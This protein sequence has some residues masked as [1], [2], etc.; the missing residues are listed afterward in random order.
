MAHTYS[1]I[2]A[3][4]IFS[5]KNREKTICSDLQERLWPYMGGIAKENKMK[6]LK[7]GGI[8]DHVHILLSLPTTIAPSKALQLIKGV[9][10]SWVHQSFPEYRG[11]EWQEGYGI[12]TIGYSQ[13]EK[14]VQ[15]IERQQEH[16]RKKTF[17]EEY[18][19]FLKKYHIEYDERY[20]WG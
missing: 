16:H 18:L 9:S 5:T 17:Q 15:Y 3:H 19:E 1:S 7:I 10:S 12:F 20:I 13:I 2:L 14:T 4:C 8:S 6:A 11:F